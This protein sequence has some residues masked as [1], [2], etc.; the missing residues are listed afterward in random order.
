M[1][2]HWLFAVAFAS[3]VVGCS[4]RLEVHVSPSG[5]DGA[6]GTAAHP[7]RTLRGARDFLRT[8]RASGRL[9]RG[10]DVWFADGVYPIS[11]PVEFSDLDSGTSGALISYRA[12]NKGAAVFV[13]SAEL[14]WSPLSSGDLHY[15]LIPE[16]A[17]RHV[18]TAA[19]PG[20]GHLSGFL[21]GAIDPKHETEHPLSV[22]ADGCR[23]KLS[24][25]P[26]ESLLRVEKFHGEPVYEGRCV[27]WITKK[28]VFDFDSPRLK[29]WSREPDLW[30]HGY[31]VFLWRDMAS[32][33]LKADPVGKTM[34]IAT[35]NSLGIGF[36]DHDAQFYVFNALSEIDSPGTWAV[37]RITRRLYVWP[38]AED[39]KIQVAES[40]HL[41]VANGLQDVIFSGFVA[42]CSRD[43]ALTFKNCRRV[44]MTA[45]TVRHT[46][47][48]GIQIEGGEDCRVEGCDL[49]D[50]G[51]GGVAV[52]GGEQERLTAAGHVVDN[53]QISHYGQVVHSGRPGIN[54]GG[55]G[56]RATHNLIHHAY[57]NGL[58]FDGNDHYVGF[59]VIHDV[60]MYNND[61][62]ALY[63]C[64]FDWTKRGSVIEHNLIHANG[65]QPHPKASP[66]IYLD[67]Y[68][69]GTIVRGNIVSAS[70]A[71][72]WVCGGNGN[73]VERN[74]IVN[75]LN[76]AISLASR[77]TDSFA[78]GT[79]S[80]GRTSK[81]YSKV[82]QNPVF[83]SVLWQTRYPVLGK[84]MDQEDPVFAHNAL[85]NVIASNV[86][87]GAGE[88]DRRQNWPAVSAYNTFDETVRLSD[89]SAFKDLEAGDL[90][91]RPGSD[92]FGIVGDLRFA[93]MGL[94]ESMNR[95]SPAVK[96][97]SDRYPFR[98]VTGKARPSDYKDGHVE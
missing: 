31:W 77:G 68:S 44:K 49:D 6:N 74:F 45:L 55:V 52:S 50:L 64:Q 28:G 87:A 3:A 16:K 33:V 23:L 65:I 35:D 85:Y 22:F 56:C 1:R 78:A 76:N 82:L 98:P 37:D 15:G 41:V 20:T 91:I 5:D 61:A 34:S 97:G 95:A 17:R 14:A 24:R 26:K 70:S 13:G 10:A 29:D 25:Y 72:I 27:G 93:E 36:K 11:D 7:L 39:S 84:V 9:D 43:T 83:T 73:R 54:L 60:C 30:A 58:T 53:C 88:L 67:D 66:G 71:G 81:L 90:D 94:Y 32:R 89:A 79:A 59:N 51:E 57:H 80:K 18:V 42:E 48:W 12:V 96:F 86:V 21:G 40:E 38:P 19:L 8:C 92:A 47:G 75:V 62:G 63:C 69:S 2:L 46:S 4:H